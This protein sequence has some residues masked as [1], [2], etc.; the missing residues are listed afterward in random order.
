VQERDQLG[1]SLAAAGVRVGPDQLAQLVKRAAEQQLEGAL[2]RLLD[3]PHIAAAWRARHGQPLRR[4]AAIDELASSMELCLWLAQQSNAELAADQIRD[5]AAGMIAARRIADVQSR[6]GAEYGQ[7]EGMG[8]NT[9][10]LVVVSCLVCVVGIANAMLVSVLERFREIATMKCLGA[11]DHFI[12][13]LFLMEASFLGLVGGVVGVVLGLVVGLGRMWLGYGRWI[14]DFF[15][16]AGLLGAAG[17]AV[18]AGLLLSTLAAIYP[19]IMAG[20]MPPLEAMR[21]E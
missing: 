19:A 9:F 16:W 8:A 21:V 12:A 18:A 7:Q 10:W 13:V 4:D 14:G 17:V 15:P 1:R 2:V 11:L 6:L 5:A 3:Q 20:R